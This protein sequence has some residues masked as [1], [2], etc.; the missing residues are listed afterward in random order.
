MAI[1]TLEQIKE[2]LRIIDQHAPFDGHED[3]L[4]QRKIDAAQNHIERLLGF[5]IEETFGGEG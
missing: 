1:V 3:D 4:L 5:R 2:Q